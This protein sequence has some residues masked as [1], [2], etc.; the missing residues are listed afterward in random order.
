MCAIPGCYI[1]EPHTHVTVG[2]LPPAPASET[3]PGG[4]LSEEEYGLFVRLVEALEKIST[5]F[6]VIC[7]ELRSRP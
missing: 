4:V 5:T 1:A 7:D 3:C 2:A 6:E